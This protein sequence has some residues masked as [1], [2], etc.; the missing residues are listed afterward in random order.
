MSSAY[1]PLCVARG[2]LCGRCAERSVV[3]PVVQL[4]LSAVYSWC[5]YMWLGVV[6]VVMVG[7]GCCNHS[8]QSNT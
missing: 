8:M 6:L 2:D 4:L 7:G 5:A 1:I 3:F